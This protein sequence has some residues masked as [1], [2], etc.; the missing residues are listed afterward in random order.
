MMTNPTMKMMARA[1]GALLI[2]LALALPSSAWAQSQKIAYVD[3]REALTKID[4]GKAAQKR[5]K[6]QLSKKQKELNKQQ[7]KVKGLKSNFE[8]QVAMMN[9]DAKRKKMKELQEELVEL[10]Q[11]YFAMQQELS[12]AEAKATKKIFDKMRKVVAEI[13]EEKGYDLVLEKGDSLVYGKVRYD[14]TDELVERYNK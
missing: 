3:L 1:L 5:L 14:L 9:E 13:A 12:Q 11:M 10:Q 7:E 2:T 8:A 6:S 4:E